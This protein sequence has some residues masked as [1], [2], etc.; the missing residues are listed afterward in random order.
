MPPVVFSHLRC[1]FI[2]GEPS[3]D[4]TCKCNAPVKPGSSYCP[5][6]HERCW[7]PPPPKPKPGERSTPNYRVVFNR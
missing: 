2:E 3:A 6:H 1:Q 5:E 4:D 7:L